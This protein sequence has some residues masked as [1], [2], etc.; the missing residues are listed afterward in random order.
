MKLDLEPHEVTIILK[1]L[2]KLPRKEA[3]T[4]VKK[5]VGEDA[6]EKL[7]HHP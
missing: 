3:E 4:L 2:D 1:G 6:E 5:I 7:K